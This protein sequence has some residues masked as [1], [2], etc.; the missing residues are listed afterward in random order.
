MPA[1]H[2]LSAFSR[3][4]FANKYKKNK[5]LL[6]S[7]LFTLI[8]GSHARASHSLSAFSRRM[9][10]NKHKKNKCLLR[11]RLFFFCAY[12]IIYYPTYSKNANLILC[13]NPDDAAPENL[14]FFI[15]GYD[16]QRHLLPRHPFHGDFEP[17]LITDR[18]HRSFLH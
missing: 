10:A 4:M 2:S 3:R 12:Y 1:S 9:F 6:R 11:S 7:R 13:F 15:D 8:S 14:S 18:K 16:L 17:D 5:C